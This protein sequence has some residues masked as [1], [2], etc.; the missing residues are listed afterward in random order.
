MGNSGNRTAQYHIILLYY[1]GIIGV[2]YFAKNS[3]RSKRERNRSA[4]PRQFQSRDRLI[5]CQHDILYTY[6][7][8]GGLHKSFNHK[9]KRY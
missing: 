6:Y 3:V 4:R 9:T 8:H 7:S 1:L 2:C 5:N